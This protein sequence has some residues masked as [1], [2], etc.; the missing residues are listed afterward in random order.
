[1]EQAAINALSFYSLE[2]AGLSER[3]SV[4]AEPISDDRQRLSKTIVTNS[5]EL[6]IGRTA[7]HNISYDNNFVSESDGR[8]HAKLRYDG[9][10]WSIQDLN[11]TNGTY[12]NGER[13]TSRQLSFG[14]LIYIM[15]LRIIVGKSFFAVNNPDGMVKLNSNILKKYEP[16]K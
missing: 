10:I 6:S 2:I 1:M 3:V 16:Q 15:G 8:G 4:F 14:D 7:Q 9:E 5:C 11:S 13:I 12:V